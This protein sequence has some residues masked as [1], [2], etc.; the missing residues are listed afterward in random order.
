M[1][2]KLISLLLCMVLLLASLPAAAYGAGSIALQID[3]RFLTDAEL[4]RFTVG[5]G[6]IWDPVSNSLTLLN[7]RFGPIHHNSEEKLTIILE[8]DH[9]TATSSTITGTDLYESGLSSNG[10]LE[11]IGWM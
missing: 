4:S 6:W 3:G 9:G 1:N 7:Y 11:I 2:K 8:D 5:K 10:P